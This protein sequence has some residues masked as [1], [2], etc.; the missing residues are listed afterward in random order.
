MEILEDIVEP[1][2]IVDQEPVHLR[3]TSGPFLVVTILGYQ[4][5]V[6]VIATRFRRQYFLIIGARSMT[7]SLE[8]LRK[9]NGGSLLGLEFWIRKSGP[10]K[11]SGYILEE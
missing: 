6:R 8:I 2:L 9:D 11:Q 7:R 1:R 4:P 10:E 3:I 5:A